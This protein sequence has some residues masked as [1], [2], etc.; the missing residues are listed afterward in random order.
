MKNHQLRILAIATFTLVLAT[1]AFAK[2]TA[3]ATINVNNQ[4]LHMINNVV[5]ITLNGGYQP[6]YQ[7]I[8]GIGTYGIQVTYGPAAVVINGFV[9]QFGTIG[10]AYTNDGTR[11]KVDFTGGTNIVIQDQQ[12]V[13]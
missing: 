11:V 13:Q 1:A 5:E 2:P 4:S 10:Y 9:T 7:L 3:T 6:V 12:V 8:P